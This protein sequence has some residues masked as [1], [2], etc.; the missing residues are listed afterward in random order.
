M[1]YR[2]VAYL[3][4]IRGDGASTCW[5]TCWELVVLLYLA[6]LVNIPDMGCPMTVSKPS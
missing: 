6:L 4:Y 1:R 2:F 5:C 3:T